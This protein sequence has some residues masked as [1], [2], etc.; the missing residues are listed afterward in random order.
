VN[1]DLVDKTMTEPPV[2]RSSRVFRATPGSICRHGGRDTGEESDPQYRLVLVDTRRK[3]SVMGAPK[4][5][6]QKQHE[7]ELGAEDSVPDLEVTD[8]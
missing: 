4:D 1:V 3:A 8:Q 2:F 6:S 5:K 7:I